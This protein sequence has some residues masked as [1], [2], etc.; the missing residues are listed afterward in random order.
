VSSVL[1]SIANEVLKS[2]VAQYNA[3]ELIGKREAVCPALTVVPWSAWRPQLAS[4]EN[5][6]SE[7]HCSS[8]ISS[9]PR[10]A[11]AFLLESVW[12]HPK[13]SQPCD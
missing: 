7:G 11:A 10:M 6:A 12:P 2:V 1:P 4:M 9:T 13:L 8:W 5:V 3:I